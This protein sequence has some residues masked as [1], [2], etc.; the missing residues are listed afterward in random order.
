MVGIDAYRDPVPPLRGCVADVER[1]GRLLERRATAVGDAFELMTLTDGAATRR[2]VIEAFRAHLATAGPQD[3]ALFYYSGHGSQERA[4]PQPVTAGPDT[5]DTLTV[6]DVLDLVNETIVLVDSRDDG[7][8]DL[9]DTELAQLVGEVSAHA[10]H[11]L[12]VLDCCHSASELRSLD[13]HRTRVRRAP[14]D[15]RARTPES[16]L[17]RTRTAGTTAVGT[18][19]AGTPSIG[20]SSG[21]GPTGE[22][23]AGPADLLNPDSGSYVLLA[24][25]RSD[26]TAKEVRIDGADRGAFSAALE[27]ALAV[28][29]GQPTYLEL[30]R[31]VSAALRNLVADQSPVLEAPT[32]S[33]TRQPFLGGIAAPDEPLLTAAYVAQRGWVLDAGRMH[34]L[35]P[36]T[37]DAPATVAL[38][39]LGSIGGSVG[40]SVTT[41]LVLDITATTSMLD[42]VDPASLDRGET[43]RA[44]VVSVGQ[45]QAVV[46]VLGTGA[47][48]QAVRAVLADSA[49]VRIA[50]GDDGDIV[51]DCTGP[52][53]QVNRI[54]GN[55][56]L[57]AEGD[58]RDAD[59]VDRIAL[60]C[61]HIGR[62]VGLAERRNPTSRLRP[63]QVTLD[64]FDRA[65]D[66]ISSADGILEVRYT[67]PDDEDGPIIAVEYANLSPR[68]LYCAVLVLTESYGIECLT[69]G[70]SVL[71]HPG[72]SARVADE[73]GRPRLRTFVSRGR[74]RTTDLLKLLVSTEPFDAQSM[75]QEELEPPAPGQGLRRGFSRPSRV[76]A[77]GQDWTTREALV[78]TVRPGGEITA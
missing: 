54:G 5:P 77:D 6:L 49:V 29:G 41:A 71:L 59:A 60:V 45:P 68:P 55:R 40:G 35:A 39:R 48:A 32:A 51:V 75:T 28:I 21:D 73:D 53:I 67:G 58:A 72:A 38:H 61:E 7:A 46:A 36:G 57:A 13:E 42:P 12:V 19:A 34:G 62:W 20:R 47:D 63:E 50:P 31:W 11:T 23:A 78:T 25:C 69:I 15:D 2:A 65:G 14:A 27:T 17:V 30:Q 9:A 10:G 4:R 33:D 24:A 52:G 1:V 8:H 18:P 56:P 26:Q 74:D 16:Y 66:P 22:A 70:G 43:Y 37:S 76:P 3:T 44:V 64:V